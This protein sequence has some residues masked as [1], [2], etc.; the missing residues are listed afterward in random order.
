[1]LLESH[2]ICFFFFS[3]KFFAVICSALTPSSFWCPCLITDHSSPQRLRQPQ[4]SQVSEGSIPR[5]LLWSC[6]NR[7]PAPT[8]NTLEAMGQRLLTYG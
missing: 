5:R 2:C 6:E 4:A 3:E 7:K 1:M 8:T